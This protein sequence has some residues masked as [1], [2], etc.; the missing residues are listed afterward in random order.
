MA[1]PR[2][3]ASHVLL[4]D[5][6]GA[7][8][9]IVLVERGSLPAAITTADCVSQD[10]LIDLLAAAAATCEG[11]ILGAAIAAPGP[12]L[13]GV[14]QLTHS[15]MRLEAEVITDRLG[16][17]RLHLVNNFTARAL[18]VPLLAPE[19]MEPIGGGIPHRDAPAAAI[20][21]SAAGLGMSILN[22]DGFVGW[23]AAAAEGGHA[24]L[25]AATDREA[26]VI[27]VLR[28]LHGHVSAEHVLSG[29]GVLDVALAVSTLAGKPERPGDLGVLLAAARGGD[30]QAREVFALVS[31]WL[32]AV[33]G[34]LVL[35]AGARSGIYVISATVL[36]WGEMLDRALVRQ[37][38]EAKG[39]MS[40]YLRDV[41]FYLVNEPNC[42]LLGL[43]ALFN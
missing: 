10:Q 29:K 25:A 24:D 9:R 22:P 6:D 15:P 16:L 19:A 5:V 27:R 12:C 11:P 3:Q 8:A 42:G 38:F 30:A 7:S 18:A 23:M 35:T 17:D 13:D 4:A 1:L 14:I 41:P 33:A 34:N 37:R 39:R 20:G 2:D 21:P 28:G 31:G 36:S 43:T 40:A 32:G 26:E